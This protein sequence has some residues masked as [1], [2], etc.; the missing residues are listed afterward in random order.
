MRPGFGQFNTPSSEFLIFCSQFGATD[1][2]LNMLSPT[3]TLPSQDGLWRLSDLV[4]LRLTI[5]QYG[6][7]LSALE[8]VPIS[9]YDQIMLGGPKRD[10]QIENMILIKLSKQW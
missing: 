9:F 5:E 6:L 3:S 7:K 8:N 1:V 10:Q 2:L 4:K